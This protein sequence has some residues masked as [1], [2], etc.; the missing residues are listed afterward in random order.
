MFKEQWYIINA[1]TLVCA[2]AVR[3]C[4]HTLNVYTLLTI[5]MRAF[6]C[7]WVIYAPF[8]RGWTTMCWP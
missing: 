8:R 5:C 6:L 4:M 1:I 7:V 2:C 3:T